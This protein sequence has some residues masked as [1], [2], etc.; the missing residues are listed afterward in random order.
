MRTKSSFPKLSGKAIL[1]PMSGVTDVAFRTLCKQYGAAMTC[2]EFVSSAAL[3]RDNKK[4]FAMLV[5][6]P[7]EKPV[8]VQIFGSS[9]AEVVDAALLVEEKF[10]VIDLNCGCPAHK[11]IKVGAG[12]A[13]LNNPEKI[14]RFVN[15]I[16]SAVS[17]PV[18]IKIR[19][20]TDEKNIN[21]VQVAKVAEDAGAAAVAVHGRTVK[22]AY[23]GL[24]DWNVIK[25]VKEAVN[26]PVI[27]NGD[28]FTPET[29]SER[30]EQSGVDAI[31]V[32]RGAIGNPFVFKQIN[33]YLKNGLYDN[34]PEKI[35]MFFDYLKLAE[36]YNIPFG[37]IKGHALSFTKGIRGGAR[38][39]EKI[40][41]TS[42][43]EVLSKI[44]NG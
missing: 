7:G 37:Q 31:L 41:P 42:S 44:L 30:L 35:S 11:V 9:E 24:A 8:A 33:D 36:K 25:K 10:D 6:D 14:G 4:T 17:K 23:S 39:R 34:V 28:A 29:F 22:Q 32:A 5:T 13:M 21:A 26:I 18:T 38:L 16:A 15:K 3:V 19:A 43:I 40:A 20:G 12:S 27:G 2:T 1:S